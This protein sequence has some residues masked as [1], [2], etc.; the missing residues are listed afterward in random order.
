VST[1]IDVSE[2]TF[3]RDVLERSFEHPVVVD[4]WAAWCGP[5][6]SLGPVLERLATEADGAWTLAKLDVDSNQSIAAAFGIQG[7]PAV[8]AFKDGRVVAE[9]TG[10][11]P[12]QQVRSWLTQLGPSEADL[13]F[14]HGHSA[15]DRGDLDEARASYVRTLELD[16]GHDVARKALAALDLRLR[17]DDLDRN[18]LNARVQ[19]DA[20]DIDAECGLADIAAAEGDHAAAAARL[21]AAI[22]KTSG[23][24][25]DRLRTHLLGLLEPLPVDD[26]VALSA[27]RDLARVLF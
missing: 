27:R 22:E 2:A 19:G 15:E 18:E 13:A 9:F 7:I 11:L 14:E 24:E 20:L 4:F 25:R 1:H 26:P 3:E 21:I 16:P 23:D 6:R 17:L 10:A 8:K 12:E 5:C